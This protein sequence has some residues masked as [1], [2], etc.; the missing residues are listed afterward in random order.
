MAAL[1]S[2]WRSSL[3]GGMQFVML[4]A[5]CGVLLGTAAPRSMLVGG[6]LVAWY[7]AYE[8]SSRSSLRTCGTY[9]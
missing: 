5:W 9:A 3:M 8:V 4:G 1:L 6:I 2:L 7:R